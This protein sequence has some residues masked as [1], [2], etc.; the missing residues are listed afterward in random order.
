MAAPVQLDLY[1]GTLDKAAAYAKG[2]GFGTGAPGEGKG[3]GTGGVP[4]DD[5]GGDDGGGR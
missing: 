5:G 3:W 2:R 4:S 1:S